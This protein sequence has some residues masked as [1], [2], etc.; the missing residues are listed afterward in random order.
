MVWYA[1]GAGGDVAADGCEVQDPGVYGTGRGKADKGP[2]RACVKGKK[3]VGGGVVLPPA[4]WRLYWPQRSV[5]PGALP[6]VSRI[7]VA[8][9]WRR[10]ARLPNVLGSILKFLMSA[11]MVVAGPRGFLM[12]VRLCL[13]LVFVSSCVG[14]VIVR[15]EFV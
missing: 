3:A 6:R 8:L 9:V 13:G 5:P 15:V 7:L 10:H 1:G 4:K 12:C 2:A 11:R 14:C